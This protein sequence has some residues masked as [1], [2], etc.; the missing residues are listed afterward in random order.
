MVRN[1]NNEFLIEDKQLFIDYAEED[2]D[3]LLQRIDKKS[4]AYHPYL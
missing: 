2:I 1:K 4:S 3:W